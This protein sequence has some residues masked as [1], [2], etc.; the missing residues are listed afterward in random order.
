VS[1]GSASNT[2]VTRRTWCPAISTSPFR[3][4][5]K[6]LWLTQKSSHAWQIPSTTYGRTKT[7]EFWKANSSAII[8]SSSLNVPFYIY[9]RWSPALRLATQLFEGFLPPTEAKDLR[10]SSTATDVKNWFASIGWL[11]RRFGHC[12]SA[13]HSQTRRG[14]GGS[15]CSNCSRASK[16]PRFSTDQVELCRHCSNCVT[17][18]RT[19]SCSA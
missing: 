12:F 16:D 8:D 19:Q 1:N 3:T 13:K 7:S 14:I 9:E 2:S 15:W 18:I 11:A 17:E 5:Q 4:S 6:S 10:Y